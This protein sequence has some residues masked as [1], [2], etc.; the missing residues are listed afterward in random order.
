MQEERI[1][2]GLVKRITLHKWIYDVY[3]RI[4][5]VIIDASGEDFNRINK[6]K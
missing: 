1:T 5:I 6:G 3:N 2:I 4:S